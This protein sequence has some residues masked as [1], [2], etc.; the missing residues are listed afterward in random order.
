MYTTKGTTR[1]VRNRIAIE[2]RIVRK[3]VRDSLAAGFA[4]SVDDGGNE[5]AGPYTKTGDLYKALMETDDD[6]LIFI[7]DGKEV[8]WVRFVYGNDGW[9]VISDYT[10]NLEEV[11]KGANELSEKLS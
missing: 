9:D 11:L 8:G 2:R 7:K 3:V 10:V 4:L 1:A 6:R 5:I